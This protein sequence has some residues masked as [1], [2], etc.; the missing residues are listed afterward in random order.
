VGTVPELMFDA[1]N[2]VSPEPAPVT[3]VNVPTLAVKLP[4][5]S[6]ATIVEAPLAEAAV[7][8]AFG[9]VPLDILEAFK[10]V[11][12]PPAPDRVINVPTLAEKLPFASLATIV[13]APLAEVA[14]V[15]AL[16]KVP[17]LMLE[18][19]NAVSA[20]PLAV[21]TLALK[22]PEASLATM[23]EAPL[24]SLA[25]VRALAIVPVLITLALIAVTFRATAPVPLKVT[26]AAVAPLVIEK[27]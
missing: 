13:E 17:V 12:A 9:I 3:V 26:A 20:E 22:L 1:F 2:E 25:V 8:F 14:V 11:I 16:A 4:E 21:I 23:V 18:A 10:A 15:R 5:A 7:V 6:L 24:A 19:F 27:F